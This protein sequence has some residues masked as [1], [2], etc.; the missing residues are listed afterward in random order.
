MG[1]AKALQSFDTIVLHE[2]G[3]NL[4]YRKISLL[5]RRNVTKHTLNAEIVH[6][7]NVEIHLGLVVGC[8]PRVS[9]VPNEIAVRRP[10]Q[11]FS[12]TQFSEVRI[13]RHKTVS[14]IKD[15]F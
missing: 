5:C 3:P 2:I 11:H 10:L 7:R 15:A 8:L 6:L 1:M 4:Q 12:V 14:P 9:L 13:L